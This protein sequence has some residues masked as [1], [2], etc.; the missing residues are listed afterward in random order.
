MAAIFIRDFPEDLHYKAKI[1]AALER[2]SLK[3][4]IV[5]ALQ[6]YLEKRGVPM[7]GTRQTEEA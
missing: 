6:E 7:E 5:K 1:Q 4:L 2:I 3:G